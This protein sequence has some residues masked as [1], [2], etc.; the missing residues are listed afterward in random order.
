MPTNPTLPTAINT[1]IHVGRPDFWV[2]AF[3]IG[4]GCTGFMVVPFSLSYMLSEIA[5]VDLETQ[6]VQSKNY[7]RKQRLP[8]GGWRPR[9]W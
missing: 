6:P 8:D 2:G 5:R 7:N 9:K 4:G 3:G 1:M